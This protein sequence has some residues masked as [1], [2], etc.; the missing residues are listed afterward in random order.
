MKKEIY[1][2]KGCVKVPVP[3]GTTF[4]VGGGE[5]EW[6]RFLGVGGQCLGHWGIEYLDRGAQRPRLLGRTA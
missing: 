1:F 5:L 2:G 4:I 3:A 6:V